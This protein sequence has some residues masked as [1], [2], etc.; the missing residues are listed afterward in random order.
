VSLSSMLKKT[1]V[2]LL[3][4]LKFLVF[5][6]MEKPLN[7]I[8]ILEVIGNIKTSENFKNHPISDF[9]LE[10]KMHYLNGL[11][12]LM[13]VDG[14]IHEKEKEYLLSLID[15]SEMGRDDTLNNLLDFCRNPDKGS[16]KEMIEEL[17][18]DLKVSKLF[19]LDSFVIS[20]KDD[21]FHEREKGFI[22]KMSEIFSISTDMISILENIATALKVKDR[23]FIIT[24]LLDNFSL[25]EEVSS[26]LAAFGMDIKDE[27]QKLFDFQFEHWE[28]E[29]GNIIYNN[30]VLINPVSN[31]QF[32]QFLNYFYYKKAVKKGENPSQFVQGESLLIDL[33]HSDISF[34]DG[35]FLCSE[36]KRSNPVTGITYPGASLF[37]KWVNE[38]IIKDESYKIDLITIIEH[39]PYDKNLKL[40]KSRKSMISEICVFNKAVLGML[41]PP[42]ASK[43]IKI[44][45]DFFE[46]TAI[47]FPSDDFTFFDISETDLSDDLTFRVMK[48]ENKEGEQND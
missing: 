31:I 17:K 24:L 32:S 30:S 21:H 23:V 29:E 9:S 4:N 38:K 1:S 14:E 10:L 44:T 15:I 16:V 34:T 2:S 12:L 41:F 28:F 47:S 39:V 3:F 40:K 26:F 13:N 7:S 45:S 46:G 6:I 33:D 27:F 20:E 5:Y 48:V 8:D 43:M 11:A 19:L 42:N 37:V 35:I 18:K 25:Y 22:S 36:D